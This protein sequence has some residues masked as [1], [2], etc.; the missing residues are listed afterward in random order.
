LFRTGYLVKI[1]V[2]SGASSGVG[3]T[4]LARNLQTLL[5]G[6]QLIKIGHGRPK[7]GIG[8]HLY[9]L[10]TSIET[11]CDNHRDAPWL[12]IESNSI[13]REM[14]P[15]LLIYLDG[16]NPKP[17]AEYARAQADIVSGQRVTAEQ[18]GEIATRLE[19]PVDMVREIVRL[20]GA[21]K[22]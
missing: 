2:I 16:P 15:D 10:G 19:I 3:K 4:S 8:N 20:S 17:S 18:I 14:E 22:A 5:P 6:A 12:L 9:P 21:G 1:I 13:L 11:L 7:A